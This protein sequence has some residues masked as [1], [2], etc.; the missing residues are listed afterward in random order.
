[1]D[2]VQG[3]V[4]PPQVAEPAFVS[5]SITKC[6]NGYLVS[7]NSQNYNNNRNSVALS[8]DEAVDLTRKYFGA[9]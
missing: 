3:P 9:A 1:M 2:E 7:A 5:I 6:D 4:C 8:I